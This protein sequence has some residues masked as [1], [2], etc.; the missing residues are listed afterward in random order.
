MHGVVSR[1]SFY[2]H[3]SMSM[4]R[5]LLTPSDPVAHFP[6]LP[7][8]EATVGNSYTWCRKCPHSEV[9]AVRVCTGRGTHKP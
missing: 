2:W 8:D 4:A 6:R 9:A 5:G 3:F 7:S 1:L